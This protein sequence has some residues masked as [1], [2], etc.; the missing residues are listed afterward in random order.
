MAYAV[1]YFYFDF[2]NDET[3]LVEI[4]LCSLILQLSKQSPQ[5]YSTLD[6]QYENRKGVPPIYDNLRDVLDKLLS[7][8]SPT[9]I[10]LDALDECKE[11]DH[12]IHFI[13]TLQNRTASPLHLLF[14][15]QSR[16]DF[17]AAFGALAHVV[18]EPVSIRDD[19]IHFVESEVGSPKL[20]HWEQHIPKI[21]VT[22]VEKSN[23]MFRL[24]A[25]LLIELSRR[26]FDRSPD[27]I[28]AKLPDD[29]FAIYARFLEGFEVDDFHHIGRFLRWILFSARP[30][31]LLE[32]EEILAFDVRPHEHVFEPIK[33]GDYANR[34]CKLLEGLVTVDRAPSMESFEGLVTGHSAESF[35]TVDSTESCEGRSSPAPLPWTDNE[36]T[37]PSLVVTLAHAS[38]ADYLMSPAF[39]EQYKCDLST[40]PSHTFI[41]QT[42]IGY[43]LHFADNP[44]NKTTFPDYPLSL[45]AAEYWGHHLRLCHDREILL[46]SALRLLESGSRQF[47]VLNNLYDIRWEMRGP[48][49]WHRKGPSPLHMC[50]K[51]GYTEGVQFLLE[52]GAAADTGDGKF[53]PSQLQV[54]SAEGYTEIVRLLLEKGADIERAEGLGG[55]ALQNAC[56]GGHT[57]IVRLLL[58]KGADIE[59]TAIFS[60]GTAVQLA[61][62]GGCTEIVR[63]LL[64]KG[65]DVERTGGFS[66]KTT[67]QLASRKG[68]AEI[69]R[70]L[71]EKG[72]DVNARG[73]TSDSAL[74]AA[75]EEDHQDVVR[76]LREHGA[77]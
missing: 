15:S 70:L 52:K 46:S 12:L 19:I 58:E 33:R 18:L 27:T 23:G 17:T 38:V 55:T 31:T 42:C 36:T 45:Y 77:K 50:S 37:G 48:P 35:D 24:A 5:P 57:E 26:K 69:V 28:L 51:I 13:S 9:Y 39:V 53:Y 4:M 61:S 68:Y 72:A 21:T 62:S 16:T 63:L 10:V 64:E 29:L 40:G 66:E 32:L 20:K 60:D 76:L 25:C 54:A 34:A 73:G 41:A 74:D 22:V 43:L 49:D 3:Q 65:A 67:L 7:E 1:G 6:Q 47:V 14:T 11:P 8:L 44:L 59:R 75:L 56:Q 2:R 71:L 30:V